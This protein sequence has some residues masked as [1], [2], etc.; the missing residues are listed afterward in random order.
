[1]KSE[2]VDKLIER[3][4][5]K[6]DWANFCPAAF[7][8]VHDIL[9]AI[10]Y[11]GKKSYPE[12]INIF[13]AFNGCPVENLKVVILGQDPYHDGSATGLCFDNHAS[14]QKI[15]PSLKTIIKEIESDIKEDKTCRIRGD[16][17]FLDHLPQQGVLLLN[18]ALTV[19]AGKAGSHTKLWEEFTEQLIQEIN[20][21]K[22][23][24]VWILW[25]NHAKGFKKYITNT[26]HYIIEGGHPSP[27]NTTVPFAGGK[28]F[29]E[30]NS[31]LKTV[32]KT[33]IQW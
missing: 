25:G 8:K 2:F 7:N 22:E 30:C 26:S 28:Y 33:P 12:D 9:N 3:K 20:S 15:S 32:N 11:A 19:Q 6:E 16:N 10:I 23:N 27:L 24:I 13:R 4:Y 29:S 1:M 17:S 31:F 21:S 14:Q 18:T 5:L